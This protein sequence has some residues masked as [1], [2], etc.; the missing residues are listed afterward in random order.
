VRCDFG[1]KAT[2][3]V[4]GLVMHD[5]E[6]LLFNLCTHVSVSLFCWHDVVLIMTCH[7]LPLGKHPSLETRMVVQR[8][9]CGVDTQC[10]QELMGRAC[11]AFA[12]VT[13]IRRSLQLTSRTRLIRLDGNQRWRRKK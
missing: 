12:I 1:W 4:C 8:H 11:K 5:V 2:S 13:K 3:L 10:Q 9:L 7:H 6:F